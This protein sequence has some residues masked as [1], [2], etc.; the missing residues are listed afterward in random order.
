MYMPGVS[1]L[2]EF[3]GQKC[4]CMGSKWECEDY[5]CPGGTFCSV[6]LDQKFECT[7][8]PICPDSATWS[9][10]ISKGCKYELSTV[11]I[12]NKQSYRHFHYFFGK[13]Y[14]ILHPMKC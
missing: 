14:V 8:D 9:Q 1:I 10:W 2:K 7:T 4:T 11:K 3:C 5:Q 12:K 6:D 13:I